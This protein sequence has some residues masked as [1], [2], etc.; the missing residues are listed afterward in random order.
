MNKSYCKDYEIIKANI[1]K[2]KDEKE[3][4]NNRRAKNKNRKL[5]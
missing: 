2:I 5:W 4:M 1:N 3:K